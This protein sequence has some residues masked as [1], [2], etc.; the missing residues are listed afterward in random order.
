MTGSK[1]GGNEEAE[2]TKTPSTETP[3]TQS[4]PPLIPSNLIPSAT[5]HQVPLVAVEALSKDPER[6]LQFLKEYN[7]SQSG[8][9]KVKAENQLKQQIEDQ[10]TKRLG[11][12]LVF[13]I[14]IS[15]LGYSGFTGNQD[16]LE[17]ITIAAISGIAGFGAAALQ[18]KKDES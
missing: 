15:V 11:M 12:G 16:F 1:Q 8:V 9:S 2:V 14:A 4:V 6:L 5:V 13:A 17:K 18:K 3:P 10:K 7:E